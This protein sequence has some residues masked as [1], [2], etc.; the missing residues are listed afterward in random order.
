MRSSLENENEARVVR[1]NDFKQQ[2][3]L[4]TYSQLPDYDD[5]QGYDMGADGIL[6]RIAHK[7]YANFHKPSWGTWK[8]HL[9]MAKN[10]KETSQRDQCCCGKR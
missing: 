3:D 1:A 7:I 10:S 9:F 5:F 8:L 2:E 4:K 6:S